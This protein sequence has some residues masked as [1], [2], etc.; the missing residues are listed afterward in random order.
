MRAL[1]GDGREAPSRSGFDTSLPTEVSTIKAMS[2]NQAQEAQTIIGALDLAPFT[3]RHTI[4]VIALLTALV[5][6]YAKPFTISFVIPGM[7]A[8]FGLTA[9]ESSYLA[10]AGLT[11]TVIGSF[12]WGFMA[13]R[14]GRRITLLWTISIFMLSTVC[15]FT[16][17]YWQTLLACLI[18]G[19]GVGGEPPIVFALAAEY[20]PARA[21][22]RLLLLLGIV[23]ATAG[24]ALAALIATA[25][26]YFLPEMH[27]WRA[28]WLLQLVPAALILLLRKRV[29]PE[30]ARFLLNRG[31]VAEARAAAE[32]LVG[33]LPK[34][35]TPIRASGQPIIGT[36]VPRLYGRTLALA[37]F[38]F[39]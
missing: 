37:F 21:R 27:A 20:L 2:T 14:I 30:S 4:F 16:M 34:D 35:A 17:E 3:R 8:M 29:V 23:G 36:P 25:S 19:F 18:M 13:D 15:G 12:F 26:N 9:V 22:A 6:D 31:H 10:V 5:F 11:G 38:S 33:P 1:H 24:Y 28:M 32:Y 39:A 7:Q